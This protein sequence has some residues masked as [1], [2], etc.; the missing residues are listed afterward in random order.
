MLPLAI[1]FN[2]F[3]YAACGALTEQSYSAW[4]KTAF[5][6]FVPSPSFVRSARDKAIVLLRTLFFVVSAL[7]LPP[8]DIEKMVSGR[9][10]RRCCDQKATARYATCS[11]REVVKGRSDVKMIEAAFR[12]HKRVILAK[13]FLGLSS[14]PA[15]MSR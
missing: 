12:P 6:R 9:A 8:L 4:I 15:D 13:T 3:G 10:K 1:K 11:D 5:R 14:K 2:C 7:A